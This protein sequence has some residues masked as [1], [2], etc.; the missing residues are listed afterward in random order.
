MSGDRLLHPQPGDN[1][2]IIQGD[3]LACV[4][5]NTYEYSDTSSH[6]VCHNLCQDNLC[7]E[8]I[9]PHYKMVHADQPDKSWSNFK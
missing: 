5:W 7:K 4:Y 3:L 8:L 1:T 9:I 2:G 6:D